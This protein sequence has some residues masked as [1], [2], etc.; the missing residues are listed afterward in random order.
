MVLKKI[1]VTFKACYINWGS[2]KSFKGFPKKCKQKRKIGRMSRMEKIITD[3]IKWKIELEMEEGKVW[4]E[5]RQRIKRVI[6]LWRG[7]GY[8]VLVEL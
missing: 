4:G 7:C 3:Q 6:G 2:Q 5:W 8:A 1:G